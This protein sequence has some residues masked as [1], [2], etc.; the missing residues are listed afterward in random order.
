MAKKYICF[1]TEHSLVDG[2]EKRT[3]VIFNGINCTEFGRPLN[4]YIH[5]WT[6]QISYGLEKY[7]LFLCSE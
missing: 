3:V 5:I 7:F 4:E 1:E 6:Y 2:N